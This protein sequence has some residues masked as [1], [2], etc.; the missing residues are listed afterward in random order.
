MALASYLTRYFLKT[1][2]DVIS[3]ALKSELKSFVNRGYDLLNEESLFS[4]FKAIIGCFCFF[5]NLLVMNSTYQQRSCCTE[6]V[7][8]EST[9]DIN[10]GKALYKSHMHYHIDYWQYEML[11]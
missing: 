7:I 9:T 2:I 10:V 8:R 11:N 4:L 3:R 6:H 5:F 1:D